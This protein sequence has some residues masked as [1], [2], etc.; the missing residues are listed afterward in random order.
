MQIKFT[1]RFL[2]DFQGLSSTLAGK[3]RELISELQ[4]VEP[5]ALRQKA[6][7][8]WRLHSLS[9][10][11]MV[12]LSVDM[13]FRVLGELDRGALI[14]HRVVK[15]D[16][17]DRA[18]V[19]RNDRAEAIAQMT[20][21]ELAP[22]DVYD[23]LR[24]FGVTEAE[25]EPFRRCSTE[26]DLLL[27]AANV[28]TATANL[29]L[30]LYETSA[31]VIPQARF[32][33]LHRDEDFARILEVGGGDW[34]IYLHPSQ[35]FLVELPASFRAAVVGSAGTG[36]TI[37][38]WHRSKNLIDDGISVG[39]VCPHKA[40][41][42]ISKNRLLG[43]VGPGSDQSYF[44]VPQ[45][46]DE[47]IQ[48]AEAVDHVIVDEA[49]EVPVTWLLKLSEKMRDTVGLTLF[50]DIN[51]LGGNIPNGD[52]TRYW[53]R[54]S[55]WKAMLG[56]FP[57]MQKFSL[58][59]NYRNAREIAEHYLAM[60]SEALPAKPVADIPLF[61]T[62]EVVQHRVKREEL[63][64]VL[65]SLLRRLLRDHLPQEIG[66]VILDQGSGAVRRALAERQLPIT[67]D[68]MQ[69]AAV[70]ATAS[71]IRGHER[72]VMIV[73]TKNADTLGRNYGVA[74]DAYI[75][76]SRAVKQLFVLEAIE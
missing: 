31:L 63:H 55:D 45:S 42:D 9:G 25:A 23:A 39:F 50:Y 57:R 8:G 38:A 65:A 72:Q 43:M 15:H 67:N 75:A 62:G 1:E 37:C 58:C 6:L 2:R 71:I 30:T 69:N 24:S 49:Q 56:R 76:M 33:V 41:L 28:S 22:G 11:N 61:E 48:L 53:H 16:S 73:T 59:I 60:L 44:F 17:A 68:P 35:A 3:C 7:P 13:N 40:V 74:I 66:V 21:D 26:D 54:I 27:A 19:N 64:D 32:R 70:I 36:K 51:Q 52:V 20:T 34:E 12:S 47:L 46:P 5:A 29:A 14:V 10:S 4:R 18:D